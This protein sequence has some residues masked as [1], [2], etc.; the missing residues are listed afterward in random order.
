MGTLDVGGRHHE[1]PELYK[2]VEET[3]AVIDPAQ[4]HDAFNKLYQTL[5]EEQ[6]QMGIGYLN[7]PWAVGPR[8]VTW[9][10]F[11]L[12]FYPSGLHTITLK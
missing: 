11:P 8:I 3:L 1:D 9:E 6:Y 5:R 7:S 12:A 10:P 2:L 4:R